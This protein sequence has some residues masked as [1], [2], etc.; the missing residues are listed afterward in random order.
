[1]AND[2]SIPDPKVALVPV[3]SITPQLLEQLRRMGL[4]APINPGELAE[5]L[6]AAGMLAPAD[7]PGAPSKTYKYKV[8]KKTWREHDLRFCEPGEPYFSNRPHFSSALEPMDEETRLATEE[9]KK[10]IDA[11][12]AKVEGKPQPQTKEQIEAIV[13]TALAKSEG[14][15][16]QRIK[17][18][19]AKNAQLEA[20]LEKATAPDPKGK[21]GRGG[22]PEDAASEGTS[23]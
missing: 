9:E 8:T 14:A 11:H 21:K 18:L 4:L 23:S 20:D 2:I 5:K 16:E 7:A 15:S 6:K 22:K 3:Q 12:R 13:A 19:E 10:R 17:D 1:M